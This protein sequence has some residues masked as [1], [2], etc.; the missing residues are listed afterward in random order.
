MAKRSTKEP[1]G[2]TSST[3]LSA[4]IVARSDFLI[5]S[6]RANDRAML[7]S[8]GPL[9]AFQASLRS[10]QPARSRMQSVPSATVTRRFGCCAASVIVLTS[11]A[12]VNHKRT[13]PRGAPACCVAVSPAR[14]TLETGCSSPSGSSLLPATSTYNVPAAALIKPTLV[15]SNMPMAKLGSCFDAAPAATRLVLEPMSVMVPPSIVANESG[16]SSCFDET[17]RAA[18]H[19]IRMGIIIA[20]TGVLFRNAE[21]ARTGSIMRRT[22]MKRP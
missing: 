21:I 2:A 6:P 15:M 3:T 8:T 5:A 20:Q 19:S 18:P 22:V 10:I 4:T 14:A 1:K 17:P 11:K 9:M 13:E 7:S 16:I 12:S